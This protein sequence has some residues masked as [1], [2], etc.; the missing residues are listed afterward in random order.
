MGPYKSG[1]EWDELGIGENIS[2]ACSNDD[3]CSY[4]EICFEGFCTVGCQRGDSFTFDM[5]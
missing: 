4:P 5:E 2:T 3:D 1:D